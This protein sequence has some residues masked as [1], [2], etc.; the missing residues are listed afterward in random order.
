MCRARDNLKLCVLLAQVA[1]VLSS[2]YDCTELAPEDV[3]AHGG[4]PQD[5]PNLCGKSRADMEAMPCTVACAGWNVVSGQQFHCRECEKAV[6]G[7]TIDTPCKSPASGL[8]SVSNF[9]RTEGLMSLYEKRTT[10]TTLH[11]NMGDGVWVAMRDELCTLFQNEMKC[12]G[13]GM[14]GQTDPADCDQAYVDKMK[15][16]FK[17]EQD[18]M[19]DWVEKTRPKKYKYK[20]HPSCFCHEINHNYVPRRWTQWDQ[21]PKE[22]D[23]GTP[24]TD[25]HPYTACNLACPGSSTTSEATGVVAG[26]GFLVLPLFSFSA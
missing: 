2:D 4:V 8:C 26:L 14:Q 13:K 6:C 9:N 22:N 20:D 19:L 5:V 23:D 18:N 17:K 16:D 7:Q 24:G 10:Y 21:L 3:A 25:F 12:G 11:E 15:A 1:S